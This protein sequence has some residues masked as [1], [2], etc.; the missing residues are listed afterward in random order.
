MIREDVEDLA[1]DAIQEYPPR[2]SGY[3]DFRIGKTSVCYR[4][5]EHYR[6]GTCQ[7]PENFQTPEHKGC[8][9]IRRVQKFREERSP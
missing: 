9:H 6:C 4:G 8:I 1:D 7:W 2:E 3:I 5:G